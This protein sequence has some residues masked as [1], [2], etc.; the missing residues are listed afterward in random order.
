VDQ[1]VQDQQ[2]AVHQRMND[3]M[4]TLISLKNQF[5]PGP[6]GPTESKRV[7]TALYDLD[8]FHPD[9]LGGNGPSATVSTVRHPDPLCADA[10]DL[11]LKAMDWVGRNVLG[12]PQRKRSR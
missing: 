8:A 9:G 10:P 4:L 2:L 3:R 6:L 1:W 11:L 12:A 5:R 7:Y